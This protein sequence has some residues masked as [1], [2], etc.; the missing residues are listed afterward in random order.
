LQ[1]THKYSGILSYSIAG[2]DYYLKELLNQ[3]E[4][5]KT[6]GL[7]GREHVRSNFLITRHIREY[8]LLFLS[9]YHDEDLVRL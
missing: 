2:T 1:I 3:P 8:L 4:Y 9:L 5:A 6:L 7:N